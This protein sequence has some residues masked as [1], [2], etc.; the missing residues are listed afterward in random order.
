M[1]SFQRSNTFHDRDKFLIVLKE[2]LGKLRTGT[3]AGMS[4]DWTKEGENDIVLMSGMG[5]NIRFQIRRSDWDCN[6][7]L[8]AALPFPQSMVENMFDGMLKDLNGL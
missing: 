8:P 7:D 1:G 3:L 4:E 6:V 5:A 2:K